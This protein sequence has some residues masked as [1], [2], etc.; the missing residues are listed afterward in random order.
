MDF[1]DFGELSGV[2]PQLATVAHVGPP[3]INIEVKLL[4]I[5]DAAVENGASPS[6]EV[7][8]ASGF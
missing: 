7:S 3:S 4:G 5:D 6:G 2:E 1:Q 8:R